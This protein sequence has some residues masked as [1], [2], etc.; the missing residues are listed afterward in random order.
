MSRRLSA[1]IFI[2]VGT[3]AA[4]GKI[5]PPP[6]NVDAPAI[7]DAP[8]VIDAPENVDAPVIIDAPEIVNYALDVTKSGAG[9]GTV[10]S[11]PAGISCGSDCSEVYPSG[12]AVTLT[13]S[14][15]VGSSFA[16]WTGGGCT[17]T[18]TCVVTLT[19]ATAVTA[20][21]SINQDS[22]TV[23]RAGNGNGTVTSNP[24][25]I[26]CGL[27]CGELY[28]FG[29]VVTLTAMPAAGSTFAGWSGG[30]CAG[31]GTCTVT[32]NG[33]TMVTGTFTLTQHTLTVT[34]AGTGN[35]TV[36]SVP[37]GIA[38]GADC[39]ETYNYGT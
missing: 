39:N 19:A 14:P 2:G 18:G 1:W 23:M 30:G 29:T 11:N 4:C 34:R 13:A 32:I 36:T 6:G 20:T 9:A 15:A 21:F 37:A 27:D 10:T 8:A 16:G 31:T 33:A 26:N 24:A 35:G 17:G 5:E 25:G 38:C 28:N 22:L 12:T 3:L 7:T